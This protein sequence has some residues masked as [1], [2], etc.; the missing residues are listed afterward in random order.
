MRGVNSGIY[1]QTIVKRDEYLNELE[2]AT[3]EH[4]KKILY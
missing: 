4:L 1:K 3:H 2:G